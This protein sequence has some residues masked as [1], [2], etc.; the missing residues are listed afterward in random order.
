MV[1]ESIR[2]LVEHS[3][4]FTSHVLVVL[5]RKSNSAIFRGRGTTHYSAAAHA[6]ESI[7]LLVKVVVVGDSRIR[8]REARETRTLR[9]C[10]FE[11]LGRSCVLE[12]C[13]TDEKSEIQAEK[14]A[15]DYRAS[16]T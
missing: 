16:T 9:P 1:V 7:L 8:V 4:P 13:C 10:Y 2:L 5:E 12:D 6:K 14:T 15:E 11:Q 3:S